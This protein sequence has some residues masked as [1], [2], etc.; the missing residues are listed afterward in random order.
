[1]KCFINAFHFVSHL[2]LYIQQFVFLKKICVYFK[3]RIQ[4]QFHCSQH[5]Q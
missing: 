4:Y 5:E 1:M 3:F 2:T